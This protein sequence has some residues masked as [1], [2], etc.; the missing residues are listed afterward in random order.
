MVIDHMEV[1]MSTQIFGIRNIY[2]QFPNLKGL[3]EK[4]KEGKKGN[5]K[6]WCSTS[7][8][9][10]SLKSLLVTVIFLEYIIFVEYISYITLDYLFE[11][12]PV[13]FQE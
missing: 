2:I 3:M 10:S 8:R 1:G 4:K 9:K 7:K 6:V 11:T 12:V 13:F 5:Y